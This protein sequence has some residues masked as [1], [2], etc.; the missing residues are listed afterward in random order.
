MSFPRNL[1]IG[2]GTKF[3]EDFF[4]IDINKSRKVDM[5]MDIAAPLP[6]DTPI[7]TERFG[8]I[9]VACVVWTIYCRNMCL[10]TCPTS[11]RL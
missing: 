6:L 8:E 2:A 10:N 3:K 1:Q 4:N 11:L 5:I 7:M 9:P